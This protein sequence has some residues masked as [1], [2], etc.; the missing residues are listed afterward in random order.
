MTSSPVTSFPAIDDSHGA[1]D[2][3]RDVQTADDSVALKKAGANLCS[4]HIADNIPSAL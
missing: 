3:L 1:L 2:Q 4:P